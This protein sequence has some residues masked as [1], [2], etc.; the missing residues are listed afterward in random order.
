MVAEMP[1]ETD[2]DFTPKIHRNRTPSNLMIPPER[3]T[4]FHEIQGSLKALHFDSFWIYFGAL[5][6]QFSALLREF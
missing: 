4:H 6:A 1:S 3:G 5:W 2:P